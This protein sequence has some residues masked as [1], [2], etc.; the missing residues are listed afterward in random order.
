M[1]SFNTVLAEIENTI[2]QYFHFVLNV[3]LFIQQ[4]IGQDNSVI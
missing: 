2:A 3:F 4:R 1:T